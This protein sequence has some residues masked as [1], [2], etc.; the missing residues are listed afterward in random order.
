MH[1]VAEEVDKIS[2]NLDVPEE[3]LT[4]EL[5]PE[6][7][8]LKCPESLSNVTEDQVSIL[9]INHLNYLERS[10]TLEL[11]KYEPKIKMIRCK[12]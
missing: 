11:K 1:I 2:L 9:F 4:K 6:I 12:F 5:D 8:K 7:L 3:W 10:I